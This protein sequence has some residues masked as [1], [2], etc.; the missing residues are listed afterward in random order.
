MIWDDKAQITAK[1]SVKEKNAKKAMHILC[2]KG[3]QQDTAAFVCGWLKSKMGRAFTNLPMKFIPNFSKGQG[4]VYNSK[5][6]HA[7]QKHM[8]LT[9]FGTRTSS[10]YD[11]DDLDARCDMI[12]GNP[13]LRELI[14]SMRTRPRPAP[15]DGSTAPPPSPVFLSI[16]LVLNAAVSLLRTQWTTQLR[17]R[18]NSA[19]F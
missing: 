19:T 6:S 12:A 4:P 9:A 3:R 15:A 16:N 14:L 13:S 1:L 11:F 2:E 17:P 7:V 10:T 18:N 8:K 5:F